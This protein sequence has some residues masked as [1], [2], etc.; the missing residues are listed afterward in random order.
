MMKFL[1]KN[2][3]NIFMKLSKLLLIAGRHLFRWFL[4]CVL[5][6][7]SLIGTF[8]LALIIWKED[9]CRFLSHLRLFQ[10]FNWRLPLPCESLL[11]N[12]LLISDSVEDLISHSVSVG[13]YFIKHVCV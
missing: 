1:V 4:W 2:F 3:C 12:E 11:L 13:D 8:L 9:L 7:L 10:M 6:G 5:L